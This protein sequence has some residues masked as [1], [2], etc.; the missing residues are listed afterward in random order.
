MV[1]EMFN[2]FYNQIRP[3]TQHL[4][5][6]A[7]K[8]YKSAKIRYEVKRLV[9][10]E[11]AKIATRANKSPYIEDHVAYLDQ[12]HEDANEGS[13]RNPPAEVKDTQASFSDAVL[14]QLNI[15]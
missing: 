9:Q 6:T 4:T 8:K 13:W 7:Q 3:L 15:I 14:K 11:I 2:M 10:D 12:S 1:P 5:D